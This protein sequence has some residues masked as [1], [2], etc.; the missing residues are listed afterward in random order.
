MSI[1]TGAESEVPAAPSAVDLGAVLAAVNAVDG[2]ASDAQLIDQITLLEQIK[3]SCAAAQARLTHTFMVSQST[4][5]AAKNVDAQVARRSIAGQIGLARRES[6]HHGS[7]HLGAAQA[8]VTEMPHTLAA[9]AAGDLSERRAILIIEQ[10]GCLTSADRTHADAVLAP[11]MAGLGNRTAQSRAAALAY[12]IDPEAVMGKI[13][14]AVKD[15]NVTLRPAPDT[16]SRLSALLP[17][18]QGVAVWAALLAAAN[19]AN[20]VGDPRSRGQVMADHLVSTM[21]GTQ[22]TGCDPYGVPHHASDQTPTPAADTAGQDTGTQRATPTT[23]GGI[24]IN[25]IMTDRTL[26]GDDNTPAHLHGYGPI[27][28]A[29]AR[30]L[31]AGQADHTTRTWIRRLYT[32]P[33]TG[34]LAAMDS[35]GRLFPQA[36]KDFLLARDHTCRTPWCD[37]PIRHLDHITPHHHGG[38]T[39][40]ANGQGLCEACNHTKQAPHWRSYASSDGTIT[41]HTPTGHSYPSHPP[42]PPTSPP[43]PDIST[44][45]GRLVELIYDAA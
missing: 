21:T 22:V 41:T 44:L 45:E 42:P 8:L 34:Q 33:H 15:R 32:D 24:H 1:S 43:W 12:Q 38:S 14:G 16:M 9:L 37:A 4:D 23:T 2:N 26:L 31:I 3:S 29:L 10:F 5:S 39:S 20:A 30:A 19:H 35:R 36:A 18:A 40:I 6:R 17:V 25:L 11:E 7:R 28:A 27:P 13:R